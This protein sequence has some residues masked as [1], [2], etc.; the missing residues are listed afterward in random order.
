[1]PDYIRYIYKDLGEINAVIFD[2]AAEKGERWPAIL[3]ISG[4]CKSRAGAKKQR[5]EGC[6]SRGEFPGIK[7][8]F[9]E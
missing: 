1:M 7:E 5:P 2:G 3:V 9:K 8:C 6:D 4:R